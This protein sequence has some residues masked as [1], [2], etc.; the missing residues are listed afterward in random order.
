M[1]T[2]PVIRDTDNI[3]QAFTGAGTTTITLG[4][5]VPSSRALS[6]KLVAGNT[7]Y[8]VAR[9]PTTGD[10]SEGEFTYNGTT[11]SQTDVWYSSNAN[12]AV[13]FPLGA[14]CEIYLDMPSR[15]LE[16]LA[17]AGYSAGV[18][19]FG[20]NQDTNPT[21]QMDFSAAS[22][23]TGLKLLAAAAGGGLA[24]SVISTATNENL[25]FDAK[26]SGTFTVQGTATGNFIVGAS[27]L[28]VDPVTGTVKAAGAVSPTAS[29]GAALG[30]TSLMWSDAFFASGAVLNFNN[31]NYTITHSAGL[32]T[33]SGALTVTGAVI[34][35]STLS[36]VGDFAVNTNK[37]NVTAS[38]GNTAIAGTLGVTGAA[39]LA[40]AT[41][42]G[43]GDRTLAIT[44]TASGNAIIALTGTGGGIGQI[45]SANHLF[46]LPAAGNQIFAGILDTSGN[47]GRLVLSG[48]SA[49]NGGGMFSWADGT[50]PTYRWHLGHEKAILGGGSTSNN[51]MLYNEATGI[52]ARFDYSTMIATFYGGLAF[53]TGGTA[54]TGGAVWT[55]S[56]IT[57]F[58]CGSSGYQWNDSGNTVARMTLSTGG[59]LAPTS[60]TV[61]S[62]AS[63]NVLFGTATSGNTS[64]L[65]GAVGVVQA[66]GVSGARVGLSLGMNSTGADDWITFHNNS[67]TQGKIHWDG[68]STWTIQ[69]VSDFNAKRNIRPMLPDTPGRILDALE[70]CHF[71]MK[72]NGVRGFGLIAQHA[73]A[74]L[75]DVK[76]DA[77]GETIAG[78]EFLPSLV[79]VGSDASRY[80]QPDYKEW[81]V[82]KEALIMVVAASEQHSRKRLDRL[83][84]HLG[85]AA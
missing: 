69:N 52:A 31:G 59:L 77:N 46:L 25:T 42:T 81:M 76:I 62:S 40:A 28:I 80:G 48:G 58:S 54:T 50:T 2:T 83:E 65:N 37:F 9:C 19:G 85:F 60:L 49:A 16:A 78:N 14:A 10:W 27:K 21:L 45:T 6:S 8:M 67:S 35:S 55:A 7:A 70:F 32:L 73:H 18:L 43:S 79:L 33:A 30:S 29:D 53:P 34:N 26:G 24:L 13:S 75:G 71:N 38:S 3:W 36:V 1:A 39:T 11:V 82:G 4:A 51:L 20:K 68:A 17:Y 61:S 72:D 84:R 56:N 44:S 66:L 41:I 57:V 64:G 74:A 5:V 15:R 23:V 47:R 63:G 22:A 12:A